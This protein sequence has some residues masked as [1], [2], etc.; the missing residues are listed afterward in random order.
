M[1][2]EQKLKVKTRGH[3]E[4]EPETEQQQEGLKLSHPDSTIPIIKV[5]KQTYKVLKILFHVQH[6]DAGDL[7]RAIK[8]DD[9]K[10]AMARIGFSVQHLHGSAWQFNPRTYTGSNASRGILFHEPHPE[11][12]VPLVLARLYGRKLERAYGCSGSSFELA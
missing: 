1:V 7:A 5:D 9:F 2:L 11:K 6:E 4:T 3:S 12:E 10:R 8:W